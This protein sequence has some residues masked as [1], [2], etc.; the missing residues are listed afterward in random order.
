[1][2]CAICG[3]GIFVRN[4]TYDLSYVTHLLEHLVE[5][6]AKLPSTS[7]RTDLMMSDAEWVW[8]QELRREKALKEVV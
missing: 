1:M 3:K 8:L 5:D 2:V 6:V 7:R 4:F